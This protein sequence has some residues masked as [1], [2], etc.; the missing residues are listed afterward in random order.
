MYA[1]L[2]VRNA[3]RSA[4]DY[5]IYFVTLVL[6]VGLFYSF[7]AITSVHYRQS[8]PVGYDLDLLK[9]FIRYP[10]ILI[11][12]LISFLVVYVNSYMIKKKHKMFAIQSILGMEQRTV[13]FLFLM[14]TLVIGAIAI[15]LGILLGVL[16][17]QMVTAVIMQSF[18][19]VYQFTFALYPDTILITITVFVCAFLL[20]GI[21]N[22][23]SIRKK[24]IIE[25]LL[26]NRVNEGRK[27]EWFMP[28]LMLVFLAV[29]LNFAYKSYQLFDKLVLGQQTIQIG[30]RRSIGLVGCMVIPILYALTILFYLVKSFINRRW[31]HLQKLVLVLTGE[32]LILVIC[33]LQLATRELPVAD[34]VINLYFIH[35]ILYFIFFIFAFFYCL[36]ELLGV[37]KEKSCRFKYKERRLFLIGQIN[38]RLRSNARLMGVLAASLLVAILTF[39]IEPLMTGW[40][41]GYL[42]Q[43]A[44][45]DIQINTSLH[46]QAEDEY[47]KNAIIDSLSSVNASLEQFEVVERTVSEEVYNQIQQNSDSEKLN[48]V[49]ENQPLAISLS[50]Y[51]SIR[52]MVG[53]KPITLKPGCY[54]CHV[55]HYMKKED[56]DE[57]LQQNSVITFNG[58]EYKADSKGWDQDPM[59]EVLTSGMTYDLVLILPDDAVEQGKVICNNYYGKVQEQISYKAACKVESKLTD[60]LMALEEKEGCRTSLR[61]KTVQRNSGINIALVMKLL[62][63]YGGV[64][65]L[66]IIFT[67]LSLQQLSDS[68]VFKQ[69]FRMIRKLGV[70]EN[71]INKI[72]LSQMGL[73]FGLPILLGSV[74]ASLFV[75]FYLTV[76]KDVIAVYIGNSVL[77]ANIRAAALILVAIAICYFIVTWLLF[78]RNI[79]EE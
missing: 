38:V 40:A 74:A 76:F 50:D 7:M 60:K 37:L 33:A 56:I 23:H 31:I 57:F 72:I 73:W 43:R 16:I 8:L 59:G 19:E 22:T 78:K 5:L 6:T 63:F 52:N 62:F 68:E 15:V 26:N 21:L 28:I 44:S 61:M 49:Y 29:G 58:V 35:A 4:K 47:I 65:L 54:A 55:A 69:R 1:K 27:R 2:V 25:F 42:E 14:E 45:F 11:T 46:T 10:I 20:I 79:A 30:V 48:R 32:I 39:M 17:N 36:S 9:Q 53:L 34:Q 75:R 66:I 24:K 3:I 51:N 18:A 67:I 70:S 71:S 77:F 12:L 64:I 41:L 13:A